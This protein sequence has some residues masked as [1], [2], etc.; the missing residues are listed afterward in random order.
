[1]IKNLLFLFIVLCFNSFSQSDSLR[2]ETETIK[3]KKS[4]YSL[5]RGVLAETKTWYLLIDDKNNYYLANLDRPNDGVYDWFIRFKDS[6]N[7]YRSTNTGGNS[8]GYGIGAYPTLHFKKENEPGEFLNFYLDKSTKNVIFLTSIADG[9]V[10]RFE[11]QS[12]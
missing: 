10:Y 11:L 7:I 4:T 12:Q 1:M 3:I 5:F 6:Q 2:S 9:L 8:S